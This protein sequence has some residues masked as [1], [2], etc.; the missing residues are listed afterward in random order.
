MLQDVRF[1]FR[2]LLK[3]RGFTLVAAL[4]L[5]LGIG[6]NATVF[7]FVNAVLIR[8]LPFED[9]ARILHLNGRSRVNSDEF[10]V[11]WLDFRDL[12]DQTRA[13]A[14]L[15]GYRG[16]S[17]SVTER[18][19][20]PDRVQGV[21][22]SA[23]GFALLRQP[24]LL[25]RTFAADEDGPDGPP[26]V[27][28]GYGVW[29]SR[30]ARDPQIIGR[31]ITVNG[32]A[33]TVVGVMPDGM[34][35]PNNADLWRP[36]VPEADDLARRDQR[37][38]NLFGRLAPGVS[39][40]EAR[41]E[42]DGL[43]RRLETQHPGINKDAGIAV[44]TFNERFNGGPIRAVFLALLGAVGFVLLIA[45]ANVANLLLA[46]SASRAREISVRIALGA[47]RA[48]I[49]RQLLIE[50]L[51]L[52]CVGGLL[53]LGLAQFG[54][55]LFDAA[56]AD[57][58]KP[59]WIQFTF[60][61][62]VFGYFAA[63]CV[64]TG[65]VFG[66]APALQVSR[67]SVNDVLKEGGRGTAGT[68][69]ARRLVSA[70]VVAEITLTLVLLV[71]AGLMIRSFLK[72]Y[73][74]DPGIET[75]RML[76]MRVQLPALKYET[77]EQRRLFYDALIARVQAIPGM[78]AAA[79]ASAV[80]LGGSESRGLD[81][82]GRPVDRPEDAP[83]TA[84]ITVSPSYFDVAKVAMRRGRGFTAAD[85]AEGSETA[86]V[87]E[88]FAARFFPNE[89]AVGRRIRLARGR[90]VP[91]PG[92]WLTI[93]G[94][95]PTIRQG[96]PQDLE[97]DAVVYLPYRLEAPDGMHILTLSSVP[98]GSLT[99]LV[100]TAVQAVDPDLPVFEIRTMD[101]FL[102]RQRWAYRV[103]GSMFTIFAGIA[104][105]LS[106][107]GIY[108]VTAYS[109]TQRTQE[110]GVRLAL[111]AAPR[112]V[113]W[114]ILRRGLGQLGLGLALGLVLAWFASMALQ[115]LVVQIPA[116]DPVTFA[117]IVGLLAAVAVAACI[118]PARRATRLDP[119]AAL[120]TE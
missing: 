114:L 11:S 26:V 47:S 33:C 115:S 45:C 63:V 81:I 2:L 31:M 105:V 88:R 15:A 82:E 58:G 104:L 85:G 70:M 59:Y 3:N 38:L 94:V 40:E 14:Q 119:L 120:R 44:M 69:R 46:R 16:A 24:A 110:I 60:D 80:P 18:G 107:V 75:A 72:L 23:N 103:F 73:A 1:A 21:Y 113:S 112:D 76:T 61:P 65:I 43:A 52:S 67:T 71:G 62:V 99:P 111:G 57:V 90:R 117:A 83:R 100:R 51:I 29:Q 4:V 5:A 102:A 74:F 97:P 84:T 50:S 95:S 93:V 25:G 89:G 55:R 98:P 7:T 86:I 27:L 39:I 36:L 64:A 32:T 108:A 96:D 20:P 78:E 91:E 22:I 35:F 13:F 109:V 68:I 9:A 12:R 37:R 77:P 87:N 19:R 53:G 66:L 30:Y 49:I 101:E 8:G 92:P 56:V 10:G 6:L 28:L 17:F 54:V 34:R 48:R 79:V 116:R 42:M 41:A 118:I 106:A